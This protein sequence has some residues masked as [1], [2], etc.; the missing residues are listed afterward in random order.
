MISATSGQAECVC[1][2]L[3]SLSSLCRVCTS[4]DQGRL[5]QTLQRMREGGS[6]A[7]V[8][9]VS[10]TTLLSW[11]ALLKFH[12]CLSSCTS[13][14][15][16]LSGRRLN[17]TAAGHH[18]S[19]RRLQSSH[20]LVTVQVTRTHKSHMLEHNFWPYLI[21]VCKLSVA[22]CQADCGNAADQHKCNPPGSGGCLNFQ[23]V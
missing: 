14:I 7:P 11:I 9:G 5:S 20:D 4:A 19:G 12:V 21:L 6:D 16:K 1:G 23:A 17:V 3:W 22:C 2:R 18:D 13:L 10:Y 8:P 15:H